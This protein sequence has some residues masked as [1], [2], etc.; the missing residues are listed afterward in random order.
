MLC[1][2]I[3]GSTTVDDMGK[4]VTSMIYYELNQIKLTA[5]VTKQKHIR[6]RISTHVVHVTRK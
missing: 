1:R 3:N 5:L 4:G 2:N 6:Y